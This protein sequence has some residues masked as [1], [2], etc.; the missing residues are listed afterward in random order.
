MVNLVVSAILGWVDF[1]PELCT[2][3]INPS[4][5]CIE[6]WSQQNMPVAAFLL[7]EDLIQVVR[8]QSTLEPATPVSLASNPPKSGSTISDPQC[9]HQ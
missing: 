9:M 6:Q 8:Y 1:L 5:S 4:I 3:Y 7:D 2:G